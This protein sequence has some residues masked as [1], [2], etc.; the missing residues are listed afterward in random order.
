MPEHWEM[1]QREQFRDGAPSY[2]VEFDPQKYATDASMITVNAALD[3]GW[4]REQLAMHAAPGTPALLWHISLAFV[5]NG[6]VPEDSRWRRYQEWM[7]SHLLMKAGGQPWPY[8]GEPGWAINPESAGV[9]P[10]LFSFWTGEFF[11]QQRTA[12]PT[13]IYFDN[14]NDLMNHKWA[15]FGY[16]DALIAKKRA[17]WREGTEW[18]VR[19]LR[20]TWDGQIVLVANWAKDK[21]RWCPY[22]DCLDGITV[23]GNPIT[24]WQKR[25]L[26]TQYMKNAMRRRRVY[27]CSWNEERSPLPAIWR[28]GTHWTERATR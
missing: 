3:F 26:M 15:T 6:Q 19:R 10:A 25:L 5:Y 4:C 2:G 24:L 17:A 16:T 18:L 23:E 8:P 13:G 12:Y 11:R 9:W 22:M 20:A 7:A 27:S 1:A 21:T 14:A 28:T